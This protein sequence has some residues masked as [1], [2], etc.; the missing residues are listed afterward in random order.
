MS[1]SD[2]SKTFAFLYKQH[3][4]FKISF[5]EKYTLNC[6]KINMQFSIASK[7]ANKKQI[8]EE[9]T[10]PMQDKTNRT[11]DQKF[12]LLNRQNPLS[13]TKSSANGPP[14][15]IK[16]SNTV[17]VCNK[18]FFMATASA[19]LSLLIYCQFPFIGIYIYLKHILTLII[20]IK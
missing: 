9:A 17:N 2:A 6:K 11:F 7:R 8:I 16:V 15:P 3:R 14:Q 12:L 5:L 10:D 18:R 1:F 20:Y 13:M 4:V 19:R